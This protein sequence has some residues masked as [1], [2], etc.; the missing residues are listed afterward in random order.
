MN[1]SEKLCKLLGIEP[2]ILLKYLIGDK[3][4]YFEHQDTKENVD[5]FEADLLKRSPI[6]G[7]HVKILE[8]VE[9]YPDMKMPN[10]FVK[11]QVLML[12][13]C[14]L[15]FLSGYTWDY[16]RFVAQ[17]FKDCEYSLLDKNNKFLDEFKQQAQQTEWD[18]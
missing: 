11:L 14:A 15:P 10:N 2:Q 1:E 9:I 7:R 18:Y 6:N 12:K 17:I 5:K 3:D 13:Y 8:R 4:D 16:E